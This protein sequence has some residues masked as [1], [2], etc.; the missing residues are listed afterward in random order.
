MIQK[1]KHHGVDMVSLPSHTSHAL[2]PFDMACF[3]PFKT[4][5]EENA[6][7]FYVE[8]EDEIE[9]GSTISPGIIV[10]IGQFL[11]LPQKLVAAP[12]VIYEPLIDYSQ[13]QILTSD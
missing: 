8:E 7:H 9:L 2:Q 11:K 10:E 4:R 1:A 13:S 5:G 3:K 12:K 6:R